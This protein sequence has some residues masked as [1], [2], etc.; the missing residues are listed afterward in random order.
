MDTET[1]Y[2]QPCRANSVSRRWETV[3]R[4]HEAVTEGSCKK[5][6]SEGSAVVEDSAVKC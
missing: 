6:T 2:K 3:S 1:L 4:R 5:P